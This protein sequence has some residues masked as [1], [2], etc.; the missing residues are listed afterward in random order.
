MIHAVIEK[1][2]VCPVSHSVESVKKD[3]DITIPLTLKKD[4]VLHSGMIL[5]MT[6]RKT[7]LPE[8]YYSTK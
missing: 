8:D 5:E 4:S 7:G 2:E 6:S 3:G 1:A